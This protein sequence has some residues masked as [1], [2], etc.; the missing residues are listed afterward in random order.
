MINRLTLRNFKSVGEQTYDFT[1][2][3]LLIG[4]NN[5]GKSTMLQ[6]LAIWQYCVDEFHRSKRS[7]S[8]GIQVVLPNFT[9]LP[10]PE[11]NLLWKDRTDRAY[12]VK[13]GIKKQEFILI[14]ILVEWQSAAGNIEEFG[15]EL[16]YHSPQTI[17]AIPIGGWAKFRAC[18]QHGFL[19]IIA[20]VPPFSGLEPTEKWLDVSPIRQQVGKGQPGS[21]LRNLL[22]RVCPVSSR[23]ADGRIVKVPHPKDWQELANI[24]ER[25]FSVKIHEPKYDSARDVYISVE[26]RQN[27]KDY[28]II[29]GGSG[30]HQTLTLLAFLYGY[31]PTTI[32][33]DEPDAHLHVNLQ[34]EILDYFKKKS[35]ERNIQFLIATHAEEFARGVDVSQIVSLLSQG[36]KRIQS[37]PEVLR[38]MADVSNE[39]IAR[40]MASPYILY[41]EGESDERILR[42]WADQ[43]GAQIAMDRVCF[44]AMG[45][46]GKENMKKGADEHF[47]ALQQIIPEVSRLLLFDYDSSDNAFHPPPDNPT[48]AEWKRKNIENYLLV[49]DVWKR[50]V[51]RQMECGEDNL[52][53]QP[54]LTA[55]YTFF[56][57][58][59]LALPP[60]KSWRNVTANIYSVVDGKRILFENDD[61]LF[62]QLRNGSPSLQL[63]REQVAMSMTADEIH[64]D[65]HHFIGKLI[66]MTGAG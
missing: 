43:C 24:I 9:A 49:P 16:R 59:N 46:G 4:R 23:G 30:F 63:L 54:V 12:P 14:E 52:F 25:W 19:P 47:A 6:A 39:E 22:L 3:D 7:G 35:I 8:V 42:A 34:R 65:V 56:N 62:H 11:F 48:L 28:D 45:G 58:Q 53:A 60:G 44:K 55:I 18:E 66:T 10:V 17:Y 36:P 26:Y 33:L 51:L 38:A 13:N 61:S 1:R 27:G 37:T 40:L 2:F 41:V 15:V 5:C 21:V 50:A 57:D 32:L 29:S 20:Y 64:D 31:Q